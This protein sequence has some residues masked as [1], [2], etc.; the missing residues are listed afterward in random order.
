MR[1]NGALACVC[2]GGAHISERDRP[3][4]MIFDYEFGMDLVA[5]TAS[6]DSSTWMLWP[7]RFS[8]CRWLELSHLFV[9]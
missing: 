7:W 4:Q 3:E 8:V 9:H 1:T 5:H 6:L 2:G